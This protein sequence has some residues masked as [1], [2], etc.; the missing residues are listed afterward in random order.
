MKKMIVSVAFMAFLWASPAFAADDAVWTLALGE[1]KIAY[2]SIKKDSIGEN[3]HF[4]KF[5]G[6]VGDDGQ[7]TVDIDVM[8]VETNVDIR[9][10]R[11]RTYVFDSE[12]PT[13]T[14]KTQVDLEKL[15]ALA[16]GETTTLDVEG[17]LDL[18]GISVPVE[19]SMFVARL[20]ADK[21]LAVTDEMIMVT[22]ED[23]GIDAGID[24]LRELAGLP[25]IT[26]VVPV[27]LRFV[28]EKG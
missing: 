5:S 27:T 3:N 10:E 22:T 25:G 19:T 15:D 7:V 24:K 20:S 1:S 13:A 14:L 21:I 26:R 4:G 28:F 12:H 2:G 11:M 16:P 9:N 18:S 23:L 6:T 17:A 8:S